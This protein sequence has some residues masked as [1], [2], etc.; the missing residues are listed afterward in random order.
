MAAHD[1]PEASL[2]AETRHACRVSRHDNHTSPKSEVPSVWTVVDSGDWTYNTGMK[3]TGTPVTKSTPE[4]IERAMANLERGLDALDSRGEEGLQDFLDQLYPGTQQTPAPP[5]DPNVKVTE[6]LTSDQAEIVS[7]EREAAELS[8]QHGPW[9]GEVPGSRRQLGNGLYAFD[10]AGDV[11]MHIVAGP[12]IPAMRY[13]PG[14]EPDPS[15]SLEVPANDTAPAAGES[16]AASIDSPE[17][18]DAMDGRGADRH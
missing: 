5:D 8:A 7:Q 10:L 9:Q 3:D 16:A 4:S 14:M 15:Q 13:H 1:A 12:P 6:G 2:W 11:P 17:F 18:R